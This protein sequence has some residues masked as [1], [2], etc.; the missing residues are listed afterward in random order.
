MA[1]EPTTYVGPSPRDPLPCTGHPLHG[2][3]IAVG[4]PAI[5]RKGAAGIQA[6]RA[7]HAFDG[8]VFLPDDATVLVNQDRI[9]GVGCG[10]A[11]ARL[12]A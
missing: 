4:V 3:G 6:I 12:R 9:V 11:L 10:L 5:V 8:R 2:A 1:P 7:T